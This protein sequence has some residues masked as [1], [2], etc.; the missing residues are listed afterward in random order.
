MLGDW[1]KVTAHESFTVTNMKDVCMIC[2]LTVDVG[3]DMYKV[4]E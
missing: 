4:D 1:G 2:F 3:H